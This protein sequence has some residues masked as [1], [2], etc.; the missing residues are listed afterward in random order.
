MTVLSTQA[1]RSA[2]FAGGEMPKFVTWGIPAET[3]SCEAF[4]E[5]GED[6]LARFGVVERIDGERNDVISG[7]ARITPEG[8]VLDAEGRAAF[9]SFTE[10][11]HLSHLKAAA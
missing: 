3:G 9:E 6:G 2:L 1:L 8:L 7:A 11:I 10:A 5:I 4:F